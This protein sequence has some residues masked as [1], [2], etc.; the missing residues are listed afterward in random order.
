MSDSSTI[1]AFDEE[2][3]NDTSK[4]LNNDSADLQAKVSEDRVFDDESCP[5]AWREESEHKHPH[6]A[7]LEEKA[8]RISDF[9][10]GAEKNGRH[11]SPVG[12][13]VT[14]AKYYLS[15]VYELFSRD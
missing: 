5:A 9:R 14:Y 3:P 1:M 15:A 8:T 7:E 2:E 11:K 6:L 12:W 10:N 4:E 13:F